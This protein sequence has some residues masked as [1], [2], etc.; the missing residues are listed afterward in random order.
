M[1]FASAALIPFSVGIHGW[2]TALIIVVGTPVAFILIQ[3]LA[4][5]TAAPG[6]ERH[7]QD[8]AG[9]ETG[10]PDDKS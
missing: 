3:M 6:L 5:F 2:L 7:T 10:G 8:H 9:S 1:S 4:V